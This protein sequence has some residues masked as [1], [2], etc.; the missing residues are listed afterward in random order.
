M[1]LLQC[2]SIQAYFLNPLL[3]CYYLGEFHSVIEELSQI[4]ITSGDYGLIPN[5]L[6][7]PIQITLQFFYASLQIFAGSVSCLH[8]NSKPSE[9]D[10]HVGSLEGTFKVINVLRLGSWVC[11]AVE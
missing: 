4:L 2:S 11:I 10:I 1:E 9:H 8:I 5:C 6:C 3:A 7:Y